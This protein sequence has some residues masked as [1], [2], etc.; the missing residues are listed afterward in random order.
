MIDREAGED[1]RR[2][3]PGS[4]LSSPCSSRGALRGDLRGGERVVSD[5]RQTI[6]RRRDVHADGVG[7][8]GGAGVSPKPFVEG[9]LAAVEG[10]ET[11]LLGKRLG[12]PVGHALLIVAEHARLCEELAQAR[13]VPRRTI[14]QL[15][16]ALPG[17]GP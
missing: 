6:Q 17:L 1:D 3:R 7:G 5:D 15:V 8:V 10:I 2:H 4:G 9:R 13:V 16:K 12:P 11:M 14:E